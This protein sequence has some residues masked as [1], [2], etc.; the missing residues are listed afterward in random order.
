MFAA[1]GV[2]DGTMLNGVRRFAR[3]VITESIIMRSKTGTVRVI[4]TEHYLQRKREV[5]PEFAA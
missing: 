5:L 1:T 2:T 3:G 4:T